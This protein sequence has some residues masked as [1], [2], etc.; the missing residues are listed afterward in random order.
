MN[1]KTTKRFFMSNRTVLKRMGEWPKKKSKAN[2]N[3]SQLFNTPP[4]K[5]LVWYGMD[6]RKLLNT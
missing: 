2:K 6:S 4:E 3:I 1:K 5:N